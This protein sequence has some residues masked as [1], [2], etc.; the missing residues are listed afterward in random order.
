MI[1][2]H[3]GQCG[4]CSHFG[5]EHANAEKLIQIHSTMKA[6]EDFLDSCGHPKLMSLHL[7]VSAGSGCDGFHPV[8][9]A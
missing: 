5:E 7:K 6:P 1:A 8:A 3:N 9:R 2:L 4:L